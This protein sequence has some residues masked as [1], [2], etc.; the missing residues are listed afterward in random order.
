MKYIIWGIV[1]YLIYKFVFELVI[2]VTKATSQ[3]KDKLHDM[4]QQQNAF[5][6]Q[7]TQQQQAPKPKS[8]PVDKGDYIEFE[9]V[10]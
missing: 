10:K 7:Q 6:Q 1:V 9:E 4:Q 2:P 8:A 5:Q 3:M